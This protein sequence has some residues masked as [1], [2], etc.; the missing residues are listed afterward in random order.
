M[1]KLIEQ[2]IKFGMVGALCFLIDYGLYTVILFVG[3]HY[4]LAALI[5]FLVSV[6]VNYILSMKFVF[7][8]RD[9]IDKKHEFMVFFILSVFGLLL[10]EILIFACFDGLYVNIKAMQDMMSEKTAQLIGKLVATFI[11]M[12][13]NFITRKIF[14]EKKETA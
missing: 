7:V 5:G 4:L 12:V 13:F 9:D 6:V 11:V 3:V 2:L 8:R 14:L 10:N 1:K